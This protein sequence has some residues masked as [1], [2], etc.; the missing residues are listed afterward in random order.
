MSDQKLFSEFTTDAG[1][2]TWRDVV[3][4]DLKG[5]PYEKLIWKTYEGINLDPYYKRFETEGMK[6]LDA[7]PGEFPYL[8]SNK[9]LN[10]ENSWQIRQ[11]LTNSNPEL[12]NKLAVE[13]LA[14][15][16]DAID[17]VFDSQMRCADNSKPVNDGVVVNGNDDLDTLLKDINSPVNFEAG[18][19]SATVFN[20]LKSRE[21]LKGSIDNDPVKDLLVTGSITESRLKEFENIFN[22]TISNKE[23]KGCV[24]SSHH[25][26]NTGASI[27]QE[28]AVLLATASEYVSRLNEK[29]SLTDIVNNME[30]SIST[31]QYYFL[32]I[33]KIKSFETAMVKYDFRF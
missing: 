3:E 6:V 28:L 9:D 18:L 21:N 24:V 20:M 7:T 1:K 16:A 10:E 27:V 29:H 17:F 25:I 26:H 14:K 13:A 5:K 31:G 22:E 32:E 30:L 8:R 11:N 15:G 33:A 12:A 19:A 2:D 23:F 4:V